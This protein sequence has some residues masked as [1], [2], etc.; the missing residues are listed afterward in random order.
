MRKFASE[1]GVDRLESQIESRRV[2]MLSDTARKVE[3]SLEGEKPRTKNRERTSSGNAP[4]GDESRNPEEDSGFPRKK[5]HYSLYDKITKEANLWQAWKQ[6]AANKGAPGCDGVTIEQYAANVRENLKELRQELRK[7]TYRP[8]PVRRHTIPKDGGGERPLGIPC[9]RDRIV[10]QAVKQVLEPIFEPKFSDFSH[11]FRPERGCTT[12]LHI[13]D[14]AVWHGYEW[15]VD[16]DLQQFFDTVDQELLLQ[17]VNEEVADG[18]VLRLIRQFLKSGVLM[19]GGDVEPTELGTPQG[20]PLSPLLANIYLH[21]FDVSMR[22]RGHRLL[23]YADDVILFARSQQE[24]VQALEDAQQ[25]LEQELKLTLHPT[26][27]RIVSIEEGF[28]FLGFRYFRDT[29]GRLQKTV[30]R[31]SEARFREA[32]RQRTPRHAGQRPTKPKRMTV[33]RLRK[34]RRVKQMLQDLNTYLRGWHGYFR[35]VRTTWDAFQDLDKFVRRR[36]RSAITGRYGNGYWHSKLPNAFLEALGLLNLAKLQH[37][38]RMGLLSVP[39]SS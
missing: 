22:A 27:T 29:K 23:R 35:Q 9:V 8:R 25:V 10:Q 34:N 3:G 16:L 31:K 38:Y 17:A 24:A 18:S 15:V 7:K 1:A 11:G 36:V 30:R 4:V 12:A 37:E 5:K 2:G 33:T 20:G 19:P 26:K 28:D 14:R 13:A 6:V 32:I 21:A 39:H